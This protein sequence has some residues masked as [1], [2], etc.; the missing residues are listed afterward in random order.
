MTI[1]ELRNTLPTMVI[2]MAK[3]AVMQ[4]VRECHMAQS[5][6]EKQAALREAGQPYNFTLKHA[7]YE[8]VRVA[9]EVLWKL[10]ESCSADCQTTIEKVAEK[11]DGY[12]DPDKYFDDFVVALEEQLGCPVT[13]R[14]VE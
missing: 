10:F 3:E 9:A 8:G 6:Y 4:G 11:R 14:T 1:S 13:I 12:G 2:W 5:E 7:Y